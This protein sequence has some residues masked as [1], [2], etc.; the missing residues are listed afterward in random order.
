MIAFVLIR[1]S[2]VTRIILK[3]NCRIIA[4][5]RKYY[6]KFHCIAVKIE[7]RFISKEEREKKEEKILDP[8]YCWTHVV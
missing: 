4:F 2:F 6:P 8:G 5:L 7:K 1:I 3:Q